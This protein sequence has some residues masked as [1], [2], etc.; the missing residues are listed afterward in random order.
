MRKGPSSLGSKLE[1]IR[2]ITVNMGLS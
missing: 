2:E 1:P